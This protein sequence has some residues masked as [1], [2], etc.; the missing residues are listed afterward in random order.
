MAHD[1]KLHDWRTTS[2]NCWTGKTGLPS[3]QVGRLFI[4]TE[5]TGGVDLDGT[6]RIFLENAQ[7]TQSVMVLEERTEKLSENPTDM[8][9]WITVPE[10]NVWAAEDS[11]ITVKIYPDTGEL[12]YVVDSGETIMYVPITLYQ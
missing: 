10:F 1:W 6:I 3:E 5:D 11:K 4:D 9:K 8:T 2:S 12:A 7:G